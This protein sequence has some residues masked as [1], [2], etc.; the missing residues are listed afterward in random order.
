VPEKQLPFD[1]QEFADIL[2]NIPS[3]VPTTGE[4]A[5]T[6]VRR[7]SLDQHPVALYIAS[8]SSEH[9]RRTQ[10]QALNKIAKLLGNPDAL[11]MDWAQVRYQHTRVLHSQLIKMYAPA[12]VNK[13]LAAL[14]SVL[15]QAFLLGQMK[16][17][18]Y[19]QA[20][21]LESVKG[22]HS[23]SGRRLTSLE[24]SALL[25]ACADD[26]RAGVRDAAIIAL[27]YA[28]GLGR[29]EIVSLDLGNYANGFLVIKG[30]K[31]KER[32]VRISSG[33][34]DALEDWINIR[35]EYQGPLFLAINKGDAIRADKRLTDQAIYGL[36]LKRAKQ[37]NVKDFSPRDLRRAFISDMLAAGS[38][39]IAVTKM[40]GLRDV[41]TT[42]R[43]DKRLADV[44]RGVVKQ[45]HVPYEKR[46]G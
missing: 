30:Q 10:R 37:A 23:R 20:I 42:M 1:S 44:E 33:A 32:I 13:F 17:D 39:P 34:I 12:T 38:D 7:I 36:L 19:Q 46:T 3:P 15:K 6:N 35:G 26:T 11:D 25:K 16:A 27:L 2:G 22:K 5:L 41:N 28:V 29:A 4:D 45:L 40:A 8:L 21:Q 14:R 18:D 31:Y 43:Y 24:I 9:S